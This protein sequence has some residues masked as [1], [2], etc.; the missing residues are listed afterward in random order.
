[1]LGKDAAVISPADPFL[2][3][4]PPEL[5]D[6]SLV[7]RAVPAELRER[8][9]VGPGTPLAYL[10]ERVPEGAS[11]RDL[12]FAAGHFDEVNL[13]WSFS[14]ELTGILGITEPMAPE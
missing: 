6:G 4:D 7:V 5:H 13:V 11:D 10:Y 9:R 2:R 8:R 12:T 3:F 14:G 1:V